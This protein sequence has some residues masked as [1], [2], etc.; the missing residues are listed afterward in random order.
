MPRSSSFGSPLRPRAEPIVSGRALAVLLLLLL[1]AVGFDRTLVVLH[2]RDAHSF[3][4][5]LAAGDY[6]H[7][8]VRQRGVDLVATVF[9]PAGRQLF[10]V[11]TLTGDRSDEHVFLVADRAG[12]YRIRVRPFTDGTHPGLY[13]AEI[14]ALRPASA[15][16]RTHAAAERDF[17]EAWAIETAAATPLPRRAIA[18]YERAARAWSRLGNHERQADALFRLAR[19]HQE[20]GLKREAVRFY[21]AAL[22]LRPAETVP[23][24]RGVLLSY[25]GAA[26]RDLG[27]WSRAR[28]FFTQAFDLHRRHGF[29]EEAAMALLNRGDLDRQQGRVLPALAS[30]ETALATLQGLGYVQAEVSVLNELGV[31]HAGLG[32]SRTALDFHGRALDL[33][34]RQQDP[35]L[36][37]STL[38]TRG[39]A[40][41]QAGNLEAAEADYQQA[42]QLPQRGAHPR[43]K[44][45]AL[46][47]LGRLAQLRGRHARAR[48]LYGQALD[49]FRARKDRPAEAITLNSLGGLALREGATLR[50]LE[51]HRQALDL[52]RKLQEPA[53]EAESRVGLAR[54]ERRRGDLGEAQKHL[55]AAI[56][57]VEWLRRQTL[58]GDLRTSILASRQTWFTFLIDLLMERHRHQPRLGFDAVAFGVSEQS[59][60]RQLLDT[61]VEDREK[62]VRNVDA[63]LLERQSVLRQRLDD[64]ENRRLRRA[65]E[66]APPAELVALGQEARAVLADYYDAEEQIRLASPWY[67]SLSLAHPLVL[68]EVQRKV[69]DDDTLL[70]EIHL[71]S[72]RSYL[73]V[74]ERRRLHSVVLPDRAVLESAARRAHPLIA[75]SHHPTH[76]AAARQAA[77]RLSRLVLGP[78]APLLATKRLVLVA[79]GALQYVPWAALPDPAF[80]GPAAV[81]PLLVERHEIVTLP[82]ASVLPVLRQQAAQRQ[83]PGEFLAILADPVYSR[84]D[85]RLPAQARSSQAPASW[86]IGLPPLARLPSSLREADAILALAAGRP[87]R[88]FLGFEASRG[89]VL[90]G[91]LAGFQI[92]HFAMHGW[93]DTEHPELSSLVLSRFTAEGR[94][95]DG[96]LRMHEIYELDL[97][98]DLVV[99]GGCR[100]ALGR[101]I[102]G[103]G[104]MGLTRGFFYAGARR[105]LVS[106]MD[107]S[108]PSTA[109]LMQRFYRALLADGLPPAAALRQAQVSMLREPRWQA[110]FHWAGFELQGDW[111]P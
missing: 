7:F 70:L 92:L 2:A 5:D 40:H 64:L 48:A 31:L 66:G 61:L 12:P 65:A 51:Y 110:P 67:A 93:I 16:D 96:R 85:P 28:T 20:A 99:L 87:V 32:Q 91:R 84:D 24:E 35:E 6:L 29:H 68:S 21:L 30:F 1:L 11:D 74:V 36:L 106:L 42:R 100:T 37:A 82:S 15:A 33:L 45:V 73:W 27:E 88:R 79:Q 97:P 63:R 18:L 104:L 38:N 101:E 4:I 13:R 77:A 109:E 41:L 19:L 14:A 72:P 76:T 17:A 62:L 54:V 46:A 103:E 47:G 98:A 55:E 69:L 94:P 53:L 22:P 102:E 81:A 50:A 25:L 107:V 58:R 49:L 57:H 80:Q 111:R 60:A 44:A 8:V 86:E 95:R 71:G 108:D 10:D 34:A 39:N 89:L 52:A 90:S 75:R 78:V 105:V 26:Y 56:R 23:R 59:R 83:R 43:G 9:D 3:R